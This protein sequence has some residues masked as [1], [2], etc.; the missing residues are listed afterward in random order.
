MAPPF[1][2]RLQ[3]QW[4]WFKTT[5]PTKTITEGENAKS[6]T[7]NFFNNQSSDL[8]TFYT[9][10]SLT[11]TMVQSR[12]GAIADEKNLIFL[13]KFNPEGFVKYYL[14]G[15]QILETSELMKDYSEK[16]DTVRHFYQFV[17]EARR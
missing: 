14:K 3:G 9:G 4:K 1:E 7:I 6:K 2:T 12:T 17:G 15:G 13:M 11:S 16:A 8:V 10:D 5:T